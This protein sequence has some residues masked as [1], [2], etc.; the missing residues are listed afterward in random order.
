MLVV[1]FDLI[2]QYLIEGLM[3]SQFLLY[4]S[5]F[6]MLLF[7]NLA[8]SITLF[9]I[10]QLMLIKNIFGINEENENCL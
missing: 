8:V 7:I 1:Y 5:N 2:F 10:L 4:S 3:F 6:S 9:P